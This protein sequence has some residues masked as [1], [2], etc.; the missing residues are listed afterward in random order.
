[1]K[2]ILV[3]TDFS[4][5]ASHAFRFA[6]EMGS[7]TKGEIYLLHIVEFPRLNGALPVPVQA[8]EQVYLKGLKEKGLKALEKF[9]A[10]GGKKVRIHFSLEHGTIASTVQK[11]ATRK[12]IDLIIVGTH[13]SSGLEEYLVGSNAEKIVQTSKVPV[14]AVKKPYG[15]SSI[16][17]LVFP[18]NLHPGQ[19]K[20]MAQV[21]ELQKFFQAKLHVLFVNTP[22]NFRRDIFIEKR[23]KEFA[24]EFQLKNYALNIFNDIDEENGIVNF[25]SRFKN[26]IIAMSTHGRRG[27]NHLFSGSVAEDVVN[28]IDCPVWTLSE[29]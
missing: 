14:I 4:N 1:M 18:T 9:K 11:F 24:Q 19:D 28:H 2:K 25:S 29:R 12:K 23:L 26:S 10:Q 7:R 3:P 17:N 5:T 16:K 22:S 6:C 13:G 27:L 8:Y 20:L 21:K 15:I